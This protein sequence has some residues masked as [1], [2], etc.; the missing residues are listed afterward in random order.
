MQRE[1]LISRNFRCF[2]FGLNDKCILFLKLFFFF[3][4][5]A[6]I[7]CGI[8]MMVM[9]SV[10]CIEEKGTVT[11]LGLGVFAGL[12]TV[13]ASGTVLLKP[14]TEDPIR[15]MSNYVPLYFAITYQDQV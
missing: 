1:R 7:V 11:N 14:E 2:M 8:I 3:F 10:A 12:A 15:L 9:G 4:R 5:F 6:Q 13:I